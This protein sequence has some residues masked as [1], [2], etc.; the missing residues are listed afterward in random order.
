MGPSHLYNVT[1]GPFLL[2]GDGVDHA[3][4]VLRGDRLGGLARERV[5]RRADQPPIASDH[6]AAAFDRT[7]DV[8]A[9]ER[10]STVI[11]PVS[12]TTRPRFSLTVTVCSP[13]TGSPGA[14]VYFSA[15]GAASETACALHLRVPSGQ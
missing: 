2:D 13:A 6:L 14:R 4:V 1:H 5:L 12:T 10:N 15:R 9:G 11:A 7:D 8:P 3:L